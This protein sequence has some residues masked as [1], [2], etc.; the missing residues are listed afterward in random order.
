MEELSAARDA[1][2]GLTKVQLLAAIAA[3]DQWLEDNQTALN[4]AIPLAARS[5]LTAQQKAWL[6]HYVLRRRNRG[7]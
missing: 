5:A 6:V 2:G 3:I 4:L 7:E 1:L